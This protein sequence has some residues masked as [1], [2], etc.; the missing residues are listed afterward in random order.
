MR[1]YFLGEGSFE[2]LMF[3]CAHE[4]NEEETEESEQ[5]TCLHIGKGAG[6]IF[7][8]E[9][10]LGDILCEESQDGRYA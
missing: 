6:A 8:G 7:W 9:T 4:R 1:G 5:R 10:E 2:K 3:E